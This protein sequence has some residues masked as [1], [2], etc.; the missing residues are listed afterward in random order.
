MIQIRLSN[1]YDT[2]QIVEFQIAMALETEEIELD[3]NNVSSG[4]IAV[5][6]DPQ[7]GKYFVATDGERVIG[8]LL[9]TPEWSDWRNKWV[10]WIQSVYI[11]PEMRNHKIF[12]KMYDHIVD[13]INGSDDIAGLRLYV[14][15]SNQKAR[16]IYKKIGMDGD[17]YQLFEFMKNNN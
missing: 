1:E 2:P 11:I 8:S 7:K 13:Y 9:I 12:R 17:H 14:D 15:I 5:Y 6:R 3:R 10:M 4:V 16:D